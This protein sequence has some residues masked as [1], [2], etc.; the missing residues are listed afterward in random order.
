MTKRLFLIALLVPSLGWAAEPA[1]DPAVSA[2][3]SMEGRY[4]IGPWEGSLQGDRCVLTNSE[5][6]AFA[7]FE[8]SAQQGQGAVT[9]RLTPVIPLRGDPDTISSKVDRQEPVRLP[10]RVD[11]GGFGIGM[12]AVV[13]ESMSKGS[14]FT[15]SDYKYDLRGFAQAYAL[16]QDCMKKTIPAALPYEPL[17]ESE[18]TK[19]AGGWQM[20]T[21]KLGNYTYAR[22]AM[23]GESELGLWVHNVDDFVLSLTGL[24]EN[25]ASTILLNGDSYGVVPQKGGVLVPLAPEQLRKLEEAGTLAVKFGSFDKSFDIKDL[26]TIVVA[27]QPYE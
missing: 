12:P 11:E 14:F 25:S 24:G 7:D 4:T 6:L 20:I 22:Y 13:L 17:A 18:P 9:L 21:L 3:T 8:L 16:M 1:A 19:L 23:L 2:L 15:V 26:R 10:Y 5:P 27:L